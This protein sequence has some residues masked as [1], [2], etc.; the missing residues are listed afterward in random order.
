MFAPQNQS[1]YACTNDKPGESPS[2][3]KSHPSSVD[4]NNTITNAISSGRMLKTEVK[5]NLVKHDL[6]EFDE[7]VEGVESK[8]KTARVLIA[9]HRCLSGTCRCLKIPA[10]DI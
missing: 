9:Q 4:V 5:L 10:A 2:A 7:G 1:K 3:P 8:L 6:K